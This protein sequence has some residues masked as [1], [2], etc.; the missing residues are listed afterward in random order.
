M[1]AHA[2]I[3]SGCN[4]LVNIDNF[5]KAVSTIISSQDSTVVMKNGIAMGIESD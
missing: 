3:F 5:F 2:T 4:S 1:F